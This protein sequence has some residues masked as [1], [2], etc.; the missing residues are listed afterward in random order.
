MKKLI[1]ISIALIICLSTVILAQIQQKTET[2]NIPLTEI[3]GKNKLEQFMLLRD[4]LLIEEVYEIG[5]MEFKDPTKRIRPQSITVYAIIVYEP[6]REKQAIRGLTL[7]CSGFHYN[8]F[9]L[10]LDEAKTLSQVLDKM[11]KLHKKLSKRKSIPDELYIRFITHS[12]LGVKLFQSKEGYAW[13]ELRSYDPSDT[14]IFYTSKENDD[15]KVYPVS[16]HSARLTIMI[17]LED[18]PRL[19]KLIDKGLEFLK[20]H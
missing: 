6:N 15:Y 7:I 14:G 12:E 10:D 1:P 2:R 20:S 8:F 5:D 19:K 16:R 11:M 9:H 3:R 17:G 13:L 4:T 18:I